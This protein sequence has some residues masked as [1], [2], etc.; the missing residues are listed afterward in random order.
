MKIVLLGPPGAGKGTQAA[1]LEKEF[2]FKRISVGD[3]L[4]KHAAEGMELG[5]R[6]K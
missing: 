4:R 3:M 1:R 6:I 2:G 5:M